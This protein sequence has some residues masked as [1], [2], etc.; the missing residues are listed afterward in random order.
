[1]DYEYFCFHSLLHIVVMDW[2][3]WNGILFIFEMD[4]FEWCCVVESDL[5]DFVGLCFCSVGLFGG[6][7]LP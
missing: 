4:T 2:N 3:E 1:M 7:T 5:N 6:D